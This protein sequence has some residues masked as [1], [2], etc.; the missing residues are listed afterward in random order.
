MAVGVEAEATALAAT[1][2]LGLERGI[3]EVEFLG[4][5]RV[6]D[7][8]MLDFLALEKGIAEIPEPG[9]GASECFALRPALTGLNALL[10]RAIKVE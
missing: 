4:L 5:E 6:D 7:D 1:E 3:E 10:A 2:F 8:E 9:R